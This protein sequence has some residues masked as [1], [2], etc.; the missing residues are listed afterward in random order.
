M[1]DQGIEMFSSWQ[2]ICLRGHLFFSLCIFLFSFFW[3]HIH[4]IGI[5]FF[6]CL[7]LYFWIFICSAANQYQTVY[8][9]FFVVFLKVIEGKKKKIL[10]FSSSVYFY[11][12]G[13]PL[14]T[15]QMAVGKLQ[16]LHK[17]F[18]PSSLAGAS[19]TQYLSRKLTTW[20]KTFPAFFSSEFFPPKGTIK[21]DWC[22][23]YWAQINI[24]I[25]QQWS[26][27]RIANMS[28]AGW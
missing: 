23:W 1:N 26:T 2:A 4:L 19:C 7:A 13:R 15:L 27:V 21:L 10:V 3:R 25:H 12:S 9:Y 24:S 14:S 11:L 17:V 28:L 20:Q 18:T 8:Y 5:Y 6:C 16:N 22:Q